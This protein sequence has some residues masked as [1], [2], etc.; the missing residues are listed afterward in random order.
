MAGVSNSRMAIDY[1]FCTFFFDVYF[2]CHE[3]FHV[4]TCFY[5]L[6]C[7]LANYFWVKKSTKLKGQITMTGMI[8][9][10]VLDVLV[11][12]LILMN[13]SDFKQ[14]KLFKN[15]LALLAFVTMILSNQLWWLKLIIVLLIST[16]LFYQRK[17]EDNI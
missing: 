14:F 12:G 16:Q 17:L 2:F 15:G 6:F 3:V 9:R 8:S 4:I 10:M 13:F 11:I 5:R 1:F 7:K